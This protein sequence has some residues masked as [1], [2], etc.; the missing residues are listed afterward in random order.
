MN[1][2]EII[3]LLE[4]KHSKDV[5]VPECKD[6]PSQYGSH[7][8]MD[9]WVMARSWS[10]PRVT[11]YE[12]KVSRSDFLRDDKWQRYLP[13]CNQFYFVCPAKLI[14]PEELPEGVGVIWVSATGSRLYTKRK[15]V[16]R[17]V[18]IPEALYRYILMS[19]AQITEPKFGG[20]PNEK[21][22]EYWKRWVEKREVNSEFGHMLSGAIAKTV[23]DE[24]LM[25]RA[26]HERLQ[27]RIERLEGIREFVRSIGLNPDNRFDVTPY[28][29]Q[30]Q[31]ERLQTVIPP[32]LHRK[33]ERLAGELMKVG[34][35]LQGLR[36]K[37]PEDMKI[38]MEV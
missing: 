31:V 29:V 6:G 27:E 19:R 28:L 24:V 12:V 1:A 33:V 26:E 23:R 18:E 22:I 14:Q 4:E 11:G 10:N 30:R 5:F 2:R 37:K 21:G 9:A 34:G 32:D 38:P 8:R 17:E 7:L 20:S 13:Y 16:Y 3:Q 36:E 25:A 35:E 15:A